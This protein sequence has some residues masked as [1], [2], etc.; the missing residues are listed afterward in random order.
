MYKTGNDLEVIL[1]LF[2]QSVF[3]FKGEFF[4]PLL[5]PCLHHQK[6]K[7]ELKIFFENDEKKPTKQW[8]KI[9]W[10]AF[11]SESSQGKEN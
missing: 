9:I 6:L 7:N 2:Y 8:K 11:E 1:F 4:P 10:Y 3:F 5:I